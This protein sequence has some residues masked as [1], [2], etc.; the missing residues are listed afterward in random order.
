MPPD[1]LGPAERVSGASASCITG[2]QHRQ[3]RSIIFSGESLALI[4]ILKI[5][6]ITR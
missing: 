1:P 3:P 6:P 5:A 4:K 2:S